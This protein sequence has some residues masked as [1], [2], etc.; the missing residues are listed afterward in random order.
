MNGLKLKRTDTHPRCGCSYMYQ[1]PEN[2]GTNRNMHFTHSNE[3][4]K[5]KG[6]LNNLQT[7]RVTISV[8]DFHSTC[9]YR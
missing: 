8:C 4:N 1:S 7:I 2:N 6:H 9:V 5:Q 3:Y